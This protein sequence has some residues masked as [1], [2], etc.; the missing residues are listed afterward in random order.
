MSQKVRI[1]SVKVDGWVYID[2]DR[3]TCSST[4]VMNW[5]SDGWRG[6]FNNF[7]QR[8]EWFG[9]KHDKELDSLTQSQ[10]KNSTEYRKALPTSVIQSMDRYEK[11]EWISSLRRVKTT[12]SGSVSRFKRL[13]DGRS[14]RAL[15]TGY[16]EVR[17]LSKKRAELIITGKNP[18]G[19]YGNGQKLNWKVRIRFRLSEPIRDYTSCMVNWDRG[20]MSFVNEPLPIDRTKTGS[21][22]GVDVGVTHT[23]TDSNGN[24]HDIPRASQDEATRYLK[25]QRKLARQDRTNEAR[26]GRK[27]KFSSNRRWATIAEMNRLSSKIACRRKDWVEKVTTDIVV[28]HDITSLEDLSPK[29]MSASGGRYKS[30]L[31]RGILESCWG[32]F[33][34]RLSFKADLAGVKVIWVNPAYTSQTCNRCGYIAR[35]NRESQA[36]FKCV[37]CGHIANA[38]INAANNILDKGLDQLFGSGH[39]L[40][41]GADL[42]PT[43]VVDL[44]N[45]GSPDETGSGSEA[46]T[47]MVMV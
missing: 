7:R 21:V 3:W 45:S 6:C 36:A 12:K 1:H 42:R 25:L 29:R 33:Q 8:R 13:K 2:E 18:S 38:D 22:V 19:M 28:N 14:F 34:T 23:L 30:G 24:H 15:G 39:G 47:S 26:G 31:N 16:T 4:E 35:E 40:G 27:A 43:G 11:K 10:F 20:T 37:K 9:Q 32:M 44:V 46:S 41:R 5:L 17:Q